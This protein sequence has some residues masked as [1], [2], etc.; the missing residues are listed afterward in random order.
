M[1]LIRT[2]NSLANQNVAAEEFEVVAVLD[3]TED[4]SEAWLD[5]A[6]LPYRLRYVKQPLAGLA[7]ARN[8][9]AKHA[10]HEVLIFLDDDCQAAPSLVRGHLAA[11]CAHG[12]VLVQG[13]Y[14]MAPDYLRGGIALVYDR[15][16]RQA[17]SAMEETSPSSWAIWGGN[18]SIRRETFFRIGGFDPERFRNYGGEDTDFGIRA[19]AAGTPMV[20]AREALS[21]HLRECDY[22]SHRRQ[23]FSSGRSL[24]RLEE[25]HGRRMESFKG[26]GL[27]GVVDRMSAISWSIPTVADA[28]GKALS[29]GLWFADRALPSTAQ[30]GLARLI[31]RHYKL[32][33]LLRG[34]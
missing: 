19:A 12:D 17:I 30:L 9:A 29:A 22:S 8:T 13:F 6:K 3:G 27:A 4:D 1:K 16:H 32:G 10:L 23:A 11:H 18:F 33:G 5:S 28:I 14:P 24:V 21:L 2:I 15:W 7:G 25:I 26:G 34:T 31:H 20:L